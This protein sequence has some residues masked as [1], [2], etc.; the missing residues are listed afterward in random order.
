MLPSGHLSLAYLVYLGSAV[1]QSRRLPARWALLPVA[2]G[3]QFPDVVDKPLAYWAIIPSGRSLTHSVFSFGIICLVVWRIAGRLQS[4]WPPGSWRERLRAITPHAFA[5][6]YVSHLIGDSY[7]L[8]LAGD[9][10]SARFLLYPI[11]VVPYAVDT[12]VSPW[13]RLL[14][15]YRNAD[16]HPNFELLLLALFVFVAIRVW[17]WGRRSRSVEKNS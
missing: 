17:T 7:G 6:G 15:I 8:L 2:I 16:T 14:T 4:R 13:I 3:S 10:W 9:L 5:V 12:E 11:Y 1:L